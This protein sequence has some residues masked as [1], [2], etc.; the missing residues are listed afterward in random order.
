MKILRSLALLVLL[1]GVAVTPWAAT[2]DPAGVPTP[3]PIARG[4]TN[5]TSFTGSRCIETNAGGTALV[6][7]A[8]ACGSSGAPTD[9]TYITQ[10]ADATLTAEQAL[11][12]LSSGC[13]SVT[14]TTGV[15]ASSGSACV[16]SST[17]IT[18]AGTANEIT[19][20]A[21]AQDL[22]ANRTWTLSI[23]T[24]LD[25]STKVLSGAS[26]LV[27]E[28][29]TANAFETTV[30]VTDPTAARTFTIPN[31]NS[32]A[33]QAITC[34]GTDKVSAMSAA[35]VFTCSADAGGG[36]SLDAITAAAADQ[37]GIANADWNIRW[38]WAKLVDSENAF[39]FGE[40]AAATGGT[41]TL[42]VPNQVLLRLATLAASTM[43]PLRVDARGVHIFSVDPV[44]AQI[45]LNSG[46]SLFPI[47]SPT[48]RNN[49]GIY[50]FDTDGFGVQAFGIAI[51][52]AHYNN[53]LLVSNVNGGV[54]STTQAA[55]L[56]HVTS[57]SSDSIFTF[58]QHNAAATASLFNFR[59]SRGTLVAPTVIT[60]DDDLGTIDFLG[61]VGATNTY[62]SAARIVGDSTGTI[63]DSA[64]GIAGIIRILTAATG[65]E[66]TERWQFDSTGNLISAGVLQ[67]NLGT[68]AN[69]SVIYCS[70]CTLANPCAGGGTG[71]LAKRL[72][73]TWVCN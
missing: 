48:A 71:A 64:T 61:Y 73:A 63:S 34:G 3:L 27:F 13:L 45:R 31:A 33:S 40:S 51:L 49:T 36:T 14:T 8:A 11:G 62:Q 35:G 54:G 53:G 67:A 68:P 6:V 23:P 38:N 24:V 69:G 16:L 2:F 28:G 9:A 47:L 21:G 66:P 4:G 19:S 57:N 72:N 70:D 22:S 1:I 5:A 17:T 42:G 26:P 65:G 56:L 10:T 55:T 25:L 46:S 41:S 12:V 43:S 58:E 60:T 15:V 44:N 59:K 37:A 20:S 39:M 18:V 50:W 29:L 52:K 32:V 30:A 7:A